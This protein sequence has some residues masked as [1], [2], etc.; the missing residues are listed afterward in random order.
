[1]STQAI[2]PTEPNQ[3]VLG[4]PSAVVKQPVHVADMLQMCGAVPQCPYD[5][6]IVWLGKIYHYLF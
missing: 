1:M 6:G 5:D 4:A 3:W 2:K